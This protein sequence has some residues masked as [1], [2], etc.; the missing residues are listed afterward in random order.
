M[1]NYL[2]GAGLI[3]SLEDYFN[4]A[5][6][7][8]NGGTFDGR[9]VISERAINELSRPQVFKRSSEYWGLGVRVISDAPDNVLPE[10]SF[11]WSGAYGTH[12][13]VD[14]FNRIIGIYMKNSRYDGGSGAVTSKNFEADVYSALS[15]RKINL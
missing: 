3:S 9:R 11:G 7:L 15:E 1:E 5:Q 8:L 14:P 10:G 4:F 2:G 6:M 12:F 13:W